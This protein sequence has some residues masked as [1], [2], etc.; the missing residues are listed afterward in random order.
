MA[1]A[2]TRGKVI[3]G[4]RSNL[5]GGLVQDFN[6]ITLVSGQS[7]TLDADVYESRIKTNGSGAMICLLPITST[8]K[9]LKL[10]QRHLVT[11]LVE[12]AANDS[13]RI[14]GATSGQIVHEGFVISGVTNYTQAVFAQVDLFSG[15]DAALFEYKGIVTASGTW[16]LLYLQGTAIPS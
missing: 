16:N 6:E 13:V 1:S 15:G 2:K 12:Q 14:Q 8:T 11:Y 10:G 5:R 4:V 9:P 3:R 7:V